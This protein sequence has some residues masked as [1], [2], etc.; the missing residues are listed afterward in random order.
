M[1]TCPDNVHLARVCLVQ[2]DLL[3]P[4]GSYQRQ[5]DAAFLHCDRCGAMKE[6][7]PAEHARLILESGEPIAH[8]YMELV[9]GVGAAEDERQAERQRVRVEE[10][11]RMIGE[12]G[13]E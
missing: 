4:D 3:Q 10:L 12:E 11:R 5:P 8:T 9:D 13:K 2:L 7:T 1:P 6:I